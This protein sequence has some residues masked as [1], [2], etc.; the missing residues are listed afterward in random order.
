MTA[1]RARRK[2]AIVEDS[3]TERSSITITV[4]IDVDVPNGS[5]HRNFSL[6]EKFIGIKLS[7]LKNVII[8]EVGDDK[9]TKA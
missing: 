1:S 8:T 4:R 9:K 6:L 7:D 2:K 3:K 5:A